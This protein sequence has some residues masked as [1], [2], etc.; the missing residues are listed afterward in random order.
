[1]GCQ[2]DNGTREYG[3]DDSEE[4]I[5]RKRCS[6]KD[7]KVGRETA[8]EFGRDD[9]AELVSESIRVEKHFL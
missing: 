5:R 6:E 3:Q 9:T 7:Q 1:M 4:M 8:V 2:R